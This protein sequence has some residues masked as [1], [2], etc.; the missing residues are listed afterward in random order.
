MQRKRARAKRI[1]IPLSTQTY[2]HSALLGAMMSLCSCPWFISTGSP[3]QSACQNHCRFLSGWVIPEPSMRM[4]D[5]SIEVLASAPNRRRQVSENHHTATNRDSCICT[6]LLSSVLSL[7]IS[8]NG[9][10]DLSAP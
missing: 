8:C 5:F 7:Y 3:L 10:K 6:S 9:G 2:T 4:L 1:Y